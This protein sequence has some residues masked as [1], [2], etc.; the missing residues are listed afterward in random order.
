MASDRLNDGFILSLSALASRL[1]DLPPAMKDIQIH[2]L[3]KLM[4]YRNIFQCD[5]VVHN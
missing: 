1:I 4:N 3:V 5:K 2:R